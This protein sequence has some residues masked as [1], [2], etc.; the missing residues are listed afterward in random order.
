MRI[1]I[2]CYHRVLRDGQSSP[3]T[4]SGFPGHVE[5]KQFRANMEILARNNM[6][7]IT[8]DDLI[9]WLKGKKQLPAH[10]VMI[11][12]D[13]NRMAVFQ[14]A[15]P[16]MEEFGFVGTVFVVSDLADGITHPHLGS[17]RD[18]PAMG[19]RDLKTL[20]D[21]GWCMGGHTQSH[22]WLK[23]FCKE[24]G[25]KAVEQEVA[26][27]KA[28]MEQMLHQDIRAFAYPGGNWS[29]EVEQIVKAYFESARHWLLNLPVDYVTQHTNI[30]RL[31]CSNIHYV[32]D[33]RTLEDWIRSAL[34]VN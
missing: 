10:P 5:A 32:T 7:T 20:M 18:F 2:L 26:S 24:Q 12:F 19:W 1:P 11:D 8:H 25:I 31:P 6:H 14:N 21:S 16:I 27:G 30:Y 23:E 9:G 3:S 29:D 15:W 13:D 28:R 33:K 22:R 34:D 4:I 17:L